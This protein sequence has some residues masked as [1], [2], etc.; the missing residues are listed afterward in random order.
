MTRLRSLSSRA[1]A[2]FELLEMRAMLSAVPAGHEFLV[3][4]LVIRAQS[5]DHAASAV[6]A[7]AVNAVIVFEGKG[8]LDRQGVFAEV[9]SPDGETTKTSFQVNSTVKGDQRSP[10][11]AAS[12]TGDFVVVWAGRGVGDKEGIF[13]QRFDAAGK[14]LGGESLVNTTT[15]GQQSAPD[16]A[17]AA[18]GSFVVA[19]SGTGAGD[20]SGIFLRRFDASG[21][22]LAGET[23]VN[24]TVDDHQTSPSVAFDGAGNL[25][26]AWQSRRQDGSDW[27]VYGQ[28]FASDG[29]RLGGETLLSETTAFSQTAPDV[30][31]DP[32]G[33]VVVGW[34]S[35]RQDGD[36]WGVVARS[37][38]A[39]GSAV[40]AEVPLNDQT[41]GNQQ[42]VAI[43]V[44]QDGQWLTAWTSGAPNGSGWEVV[45]RSFEPDGS[46][47]ES[48]RVNEE[49]GGAN[50]GHQQAPAIVL[51]GNRALMAWSG[52]GVEDRH[53]VYSRRY[54]I[55]A[56]DGLQ[57]SPDL[58]PIDDRNGSV[59]APIEVIV[60]ATDPNFSDT[61]TFLLDVDNS[62]A[63]A[64]LEQI[65]NY[66]A[67]IRWTPPAAALGQTIPFRVLVVDDGEPP[68]ADS[69]EFSV[70]VPESAASSGLV[71]AA[72]DDAFAS[73]G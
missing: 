46:A 11:V 61:L 1:N 50:S 43:A 41:A 64:I 7:T 2:R 73:F 12:P 26:V 18:D 25:V 67:R 58:A 63:G 31:T 42:D 30:S 48:A 71:E 33:G 9:L 36:S 16:V 51:T 57:Q 20:V 17:M 8:P 22:P 29:S 32:T 44:T 62:P 27:G 56:A 72:A 55:D 6:A 34:Q 45:T 15:G 24:A 52:A 4:D 70:V 13:L 10:A 66:T 3:N 65:D 54:D 35:R 49:V 23:L 60:T 28:W 40:S 59:G 47:N 21:V 14:R 53:G 68:L 5:I 19:W 37:F 38:D 39:G 69:E